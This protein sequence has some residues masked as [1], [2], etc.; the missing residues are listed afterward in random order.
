MNQIDISTHLGRL[1][2]I[3]TVYDQA[4]ELSD[5]KIAFKSMVLANSMI[6][7]FERLSLR[8]SKI[9]DKLVDL[10]LE[11]EP[12]LKNAVDLS[13]AEHGATVLFSEFLRNGKFSKAV[14]LIK[15]KHRHF[16]TAERNFFNFQM[17]RIKRHNKRS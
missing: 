12:V 17:L 15:L 3:Q 5:T 13:W 8:K 9:M 14:S 6:I 4:Q 11:P 1:E 16:V 10:G 7:E 2:A